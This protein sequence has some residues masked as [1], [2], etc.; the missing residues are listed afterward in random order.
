MKIIHTADWHLGHKILDFDREDEFVFFFDQL[1]ELVQSEHPDVLIVAGDVFD[2]SMPHLDA[3]RLYNDN[4]K[5]LHQACSTMTIVVIAGNH[6]SRQRLELL[7]DLWQMVNVHVIG[8]YQRDDDGKVLLERHLIPIFNDN[9]QIGSIIA[10]PY[11]F[12]NNIPGEA[13][14]AEERL[15]ILIKKL[16]DMA[17]Q[18]QGNADNIFCVG[19]MT[20]DGKM[21]E[22]GYEEALST[23]VFDKRIKYV[24]LG[25]IHNYNYLGKEHIQYAGSPIALS[26]DETF[27]HRV[28]VIETTNDNNNLIIRDHEIKQLR[29]MI[30]ANSTPMSAD[31]ILHM[32]KDMDKSS[33]MYLKFIKANDGITVSNLH[34]TLQMLFDDSEVRYCNVELEK[35]HS[36]K[37][38]EDKIEVDYE[39]FCEEKPINIAKRY[40][41]EKYN[42]LDMPSELQTRFI[43]IINEIEEEERQ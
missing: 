7:D 25:H 29:P 2:R 19:H 18:S 38:K 26:F 28:V 39:T 11:C 21:N 15:Q 35:S 32:A 4:V 40:Y 10:L 24:A 8:T 36:I 17:V 43:Q 12:T 41:K 5:R 34:T 1:V 42:G 20:I 14:T 23:S 9:K 3:Q 22:I 31:E 33:P 27:T 13:P 6:D 30:I 37:S 16:T